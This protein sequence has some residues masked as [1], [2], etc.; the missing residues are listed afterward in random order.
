MNLV[1]VALSRL[2]LASLFLL[3]MACQT[4]SEFYEIPDPALIEY[5][6]V[7]QSQNFQPLSTMD[8]GRRPFASYSTT[9][10]WIRNNGDLPALFKH[11]WIEAD[12][13]EAFEVESHCPAQLGRGETCR[14]TVAYSPMTVGETP[15]T[16]KVSYMDGQGHGLVG[17][18][19]VKSMATNLA[20]LKLEIEKIDVNTNTIGY[21][22]S[23]Y[24]R[25]LYNGSLLK[26]KSFTIEP[27]KG[28]VISDPTQNDFAIDRSGATT[29][30]SIIQDDCL[31]KVNFSPKSVG[32]RSATFGINYFN[33]A[34]VLKLEG[35]VTGTGLAAVVLAQLGSPGLDFGSMTSAPPIPKTLNLP[36][37]FFGSVPAD[38]VV[39][40]GPKTNAF[41]LDLDK[42]SCKPGSIAGGCSLSVQFSP[43]L[44]QV[45]TDSI[46]IEYKSNGQTIPSLVVPLKGTG[47]SAALI[48]VNT[49]SLAFGNIPAYKSITKTFTL[50]NAGQ[51]SVSNLSTLT[52]SGGPV[53]SGSFAT[54][55]STLAPGASCALSIIFKSPTAVLQNS[56]MSFS[57][58]D[59]RINQIISL[60]A[61]GAGTAPLVMEGSKTIDFGNV[62]I[63]HPSMPKVLTTSL[64][65]FGTTAL[66]NGAQLVLNPLALTDPF[67]HQATNLIGASSTCRAPLD[68]KKSNVCNFGIT[69]VTNV[70]FPPDIAMTQ[71]FTLNYEDD[72]GVGKGVL[73][74][75]AKMTPRLP[76]TLALVGVPFIAPVSVNH[77]ITTTLSFKNS[78]AYF[79]AGFKGLSLDGDASFAV[80]TNGCS[81]GAAANATCAV[82]V[83]FNPKSVGTFTTKLN[84]V[85]HDQIQ[86][87][88]VTVPLSGVGSSDV[89]LLAA[90]NVIDFGNV[91]VGDTIPQK[92]ILLS[93][94]GKSAWTFSS[95]ATKPF[96]LDA[97]M[98][99]SE[100]DCTLSFS[101][102]PEV[103]GS[104]SATVTFN[105]APALVAPGKLTFTVKGTA[106]L[107]TPT[108]SLSPLRLTKTL[109]GKKSVHN[110][111]LKNS[112]NRAATNITV[113]PLSDK[114][115]LGS[116]NC[117]TLA[118]N[119]SCTIKVEFT[120]DSLVPVQAN[121]KVNFESS[122]QPTSQNYLLS[123]Y[124]TQMMKVFTGG[125]QTCLINELG[126]VLCWGRNA[127]GQLGLGNTNSIK[128]SPT[129]SSPLNFGGGVVRKLALGDTHTCALVDDLPQKGLVVCFGSSSQGKLGFNPNTAYVSSPP[130]TGAGKI[131]SLS[132]GEEAT[133]I[134]AGFEHTCALLKS[135]RVKCWGGNS[136]GQLG[137]ESP[138]QSGT[139]NLNQDASAISAG[140]GHTCALLKD[141]TSR[142]WGD[143]FYGQL[144]MGDDVERM[145]LVSGDLSS[146]KP[147]DWGKNISLKSIT[148]SSGAFTCTVSVAGGLK[149]CGKTVANENS[150]TPFYGVLGNCYARASQ[151]SV[152]SLCKDSPNWKPAKSIGYLETD[153]GDRL[154]SLNLSHSLVSDVVL[155]P[156]FGCALTS[157]Q[158]LKCWGMNEA[159]QLGLGHRTSLGSTVS[160]MENLPTTLS[161]VLQAA[162]G[163]SHVCAVMLDN[164]LKCWGTNIENASGQNVMT[165]VTA[166]TKASVL[167]PVYDG[168]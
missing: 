21:T 3:M 164:T 22:L 72:S 122:G 159:G 20:S 92:N 4:Q 5:G 93:Y 67:S 25:V 74:F 88:I 120:P 157:G 40:K 94:F 45:Y 86:N 65:I 17:S 90:S 69:L 53:F 10:I 97:Q 136:S 76:P 13:V 42:S 60:S 24:F 31:I 121:V 118:P 133:D 68:P 166:D 115:A 84:M 23:A 64:S 44:N 110:L 100:Q 103:A 163:Y 37:T 75:T 152:Y 2:T 111:T 165:G 32:G 142:C 143:N 148:A 85:Y 126:K 70:G 141:G 49:P 108:L 155:G 55:C 117:T 33:G 77:S 52:I 46:T 119:D 15:G 128:T 48:N 50:T 82:T 124:G 139:V 78:S 26:G 127:Q 138:L 38:S 43:L 80:M 58:F 34:E 18:I 62:M 39:I 154:F 51:T 27:A 107:R 79:A 144:G 47:V 30:G 66:S 158:E 71:P 116:H 6:E 113:D 28:V 56:E 54:T 1:S 95:N 81:G 168:R 11:F 7:D 87:Q 125:Y 98:C 147:I 101:F 36:I 151:N 109:V 114:F 137:I 19:P 149:C 41:A 8:M 140:A 83:K 29:C 161:D 135:G 123:G 12:A 145:G 134:S 160:E 112:G 89:T 131:A 9:D 106:L 156:D 61:S 59:G 129:N 153:M 130:L 146:L 102:T 16:L 35:E 162:A 104:F 150:K 167:L 96:G 132:L 14:I 73:N 63:G 91:Y 57:Y 105:Y 99:G